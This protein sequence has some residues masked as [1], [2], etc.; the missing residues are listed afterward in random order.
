MPHAHLS[1]SSSEFGTT[2]PFV[3]IVLGVRRQLMVPAFLIIYFE[4]SIYN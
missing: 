1:S 3:A 4:T 2:G